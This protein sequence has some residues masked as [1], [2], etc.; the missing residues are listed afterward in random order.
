MT[1]FLFQLRNELWKLFGKK[2]TYIGF[3]MFLVAQNAILILLR[4]SHVPKQ[5]ARLLQMNGVMAG[6]NYI[7]I[8]TLGTMMVALIGL[9]LLPLYAALVGGD[10]VAK[11]AEDGSLRMILCRPISRLRLLMLKWLAGVLFAFTL[12][13][14]LGLFGLLFASFW[15]PWGGLFV[16]PPN[17]ALF[18]ATEGLHRYL[19]MSVFLLPKTVTIMTMGFMFSCCN[20]KPTAATILALSLMMISGILQQVP[21]F[22]D[23]QDWF[24]SYH[25]DIWQSVLAA[26]IPWWKVGQSLSILLGYNV[27]FLVIGTVMFH[28]RDI[29]S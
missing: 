21:F 9:S 8:L 28:V 12:V 27:T 4:F 24:I 18:N 7:S 22:S 2:R 11:E 5:M 3:I 29:K 15:F 14:S 26:R 19:F 25:V 20:M 10:L 1:M 23:F 16:W 6:G 17:F 13:L